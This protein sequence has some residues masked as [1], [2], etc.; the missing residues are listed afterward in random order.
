MFKSFEKNHSI[1][2]SLLLLA[3]GC[4]SSKG[5]EVKDSY[6]TSGIGHSD[7][8]ELL[9]YIK[10]DRFTQKNPKF[11]MDFEIEFCNGMNCRLKIQLVSIWIVCN[12]LFKGN[13]KQE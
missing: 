5:W 12:Y 11:S 8:A 2:F 13:N 6:L 3:N 9:I 10:V 4:R 7:D 1:V